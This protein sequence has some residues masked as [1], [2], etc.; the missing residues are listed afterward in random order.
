MS[1]PG[2]HV[3]ARLEEELTRMTARA[4]MATHLTV[5]WMPGASQVLSG[6]VKGDS[7]MIYEEEETKAVATLRHEVID[8]LVS[9]AIMPYKEVTNLLIQRV[10]E[11]A[12][13][14]KESIVYALIQLIDEEDDW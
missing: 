14:R 11:D 8:H 10:N 2:G 3:Q 4:G 7:I 9:Q 12:Y 1:L 5:M 6:E 13:R